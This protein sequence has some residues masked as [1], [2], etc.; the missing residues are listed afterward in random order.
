MFAAQYI[1]NKRKG[2][3]LLLPIIQRNEIKN[4][5]YLVV[6]S[7]NCDLGKRDNI[8]YTGSITDDR[9][10]ALTYSA[11]DFFIL[12]SR[13]DNLP[14]TMLESIVCGKPVI[15]FPIGETKELLEVNKFGVLTSEI[16][17]RSLES[18]MNQSIANGD[19]FDI[20]NLVNFSIV[21]FSIDRVIEEYRKVYIKI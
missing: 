11:A 14:N 21:N 1:A 17:K 6:G 16:S 3:D 12:P 4:A 15:S 8:I 5:Y 20:D 7:N 9:L 19:K 10:M 13:E 2:F 18:V